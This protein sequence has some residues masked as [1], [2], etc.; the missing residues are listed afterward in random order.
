[1]Q[2]RTRAGADEVTSSARGIFRFSRKPGRLFQI[3]AGWSGKT[4]VA[5]AG[6]EYGIWNEKEMF[7][8]I[9]QPLPCAADKQKHGNSETR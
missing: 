1:V 6:T 8:Q 2:I 3:S 4:R 7:L 5:S 9:S